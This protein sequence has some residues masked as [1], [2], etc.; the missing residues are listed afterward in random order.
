[1]NSS[2]KKFLELIDKKTL[3]VAEIGQAHEGSINIAHSY[4]DA[5]ADSGADVV[6]FQCHYANEEST[7]DEPFRVKFSYNDKTRFDYWKRMEFS[8]LEWKALSIHAKKRGL[9]FMCS[10]FS[11]KAFNIINKLD[12]CAWKIASGE[13]NNKII[14]NKSLKTKL[15]II[16]STGLSNFSEVKKINTFLKKRKAKYIILQCTSK[17][18]TRLEEVGINNLYE[19]KDKLKCK[20]GLSDHSGTIYPSVYASAIGA[21]LVEVHVT[22][23]KKMFGVDAH[24][25]LDMNELKNLSSFTNNFKILKDNKIEKDI[26]DKILSNYKKIFGKSICINKK[27][28]KGERIRNQDIIFKKPGFGISPK[29]IKKVIGKTAKK[30]LSP[31]RLILHKDLK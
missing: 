4:I 20:Y 10:V 19:F 18:P 23:N 3:I 7:L 26:S 5:C 22:F 12:I 21:S 29:F 17:Y 16:I 27:I 13:I 9:L 6:K 30:N 24:S 28:L 1:M 31:D 15:P 14:I 11:E 25:S 2:S 8:P